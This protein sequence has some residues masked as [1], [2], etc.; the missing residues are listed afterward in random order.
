[1]LKLHASYASIGRE[2]KL[3]F[4]DLAKGMSEQLEEVQNLRQQLSK[5]NKNFLTTSKSN[6]D[7]LNAIVKEERMR[8]AEERQVLLSQIA[9]L[10]NTAAET[11]DHRVQQRLG[12]LNEKMDAAVPN[13]QAEYDAY[14]K[15]MDAWATT[16]SGLIESIIKSRDKIK[17]K[18]CADYTVR[19]LIYKFAI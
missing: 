5:A 14:D 3:A 8:A 6:H 9:V 4:D 7:Q 10:I 12:Q 13:V 18:V 15:G 2:F 11:Q 19:Y 16:S 1:M 17:A